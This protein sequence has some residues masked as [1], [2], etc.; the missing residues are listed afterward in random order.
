MGTEWKPA[1][2]E[3]VHSEQDGRVLRCFKDGHYNRCVRLV[4]PLTRTVD[5]MDWFGPGRRRYRRDEFDSAGYLAKR[6]DYDPESGN[7]VQ[8]RFYGIDGGCFMTASVNSETGRWTCA[9]LHR[10]DLELKSMVDFYSLAFTELLCEE[11]HPTLTT[12][13]RDHLDNFGGRTFDQAVW[14]ISHPDLRWVAVAHSNHYR[15]PYTTGSRLAAGWRPLFDHHSQLDAVVTWTR[16]QGQDFHVDEPKLPEPSVCPPVAPPVVDRPSAPEG[17]R[18]VMVAR[19]APDKRIDLALRVMARIH[20]KFPDAVLDIY[21]FGYG[22]DYE[23]KIRAQIDQLDLHGT[24]R[25]PGFVNGLD[26]LYDGASAML[27]TSAREGLGLVLLEAISRGVPVV[28]TDTNYGPR[29]LIRDGDNG[30]LCGLDD[31]DGLV[32]ALE[33]ILADPESQRSLAAGA[34]ATAAE[35][36]PQA[37]TRFWEDVLLASSAHQPAVPGTEAQQ[38]LSHGDP[39]S[40]PH[41]RPVTTTSSARRIP[42]AVVAATTEATRSVLVAMD[43]H[44]ERELV[45][46]ACVDGEE[47]IRVSPRHGAWSVILPNSPRNSILDLYLICED[48]VERRVDAHAG[49]PADLAGGWRLYATAHSVLSLKR[50]AG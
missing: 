4:E 39:R 9:T 45:L 49:L 16:H 18:L 26:K 36:T 28:A 5:F 7:P 32:Q 13:F 25:F 20:E 44:E 17:R 11:D 33:R 22:D 19:I 3:I 48:G 2:D 38:A 8:R 1:P 21:G 29:D 42:P 27:F 50:I 24:V 43:P 12:E 40:A 31:E 10:R 14:G 37:F 30:F 41:A 34:I 23:A 46:R 47:S 15:A 6:I 35:H